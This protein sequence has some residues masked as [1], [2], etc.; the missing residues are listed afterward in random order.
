MV[1][2]GGACILRE[3]LEEEGGGLAAINGVA[4][5]CLL[6]RELSGDETVPAQRGTCVIENRRVRMKI[7]YPLK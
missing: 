5:C 2:Y 4:G 1:I 6:M 7:D 3:T